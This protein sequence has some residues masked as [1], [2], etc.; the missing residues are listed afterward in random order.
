MENKEIDWNYIVQYADQQESVQE[1]CQMQKKTLSVVSIS[2]S[3]EEKS[4]HQKS[5]EV[6]Y[7]FLEMRN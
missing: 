4:Y 7:I 3:F 1:F 5:F 2:K 6:F